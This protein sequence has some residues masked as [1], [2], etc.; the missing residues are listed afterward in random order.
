MNLPILGTGAGA[1]LAPQQSESRTGLQTEDNRQFIKLDG[2]GEQAAACLDGSPYAFY[3]WPGN[4]SEWSIFI[5]G[6]GWCLTEALCESRAATNLGSSLGYDPSGAWG[7]P[8]PGAKTGGPPAY[9]CQGLDPNCTRVF[10]PYCDGS[11]FTSQRASPWPVNG[12]NSSLTFRGLANLDRTLDV[13]EERFGFANAQRLVL[14]GGSAGGLS[15]YIHLDHVADRL[16]AAQVHA[17]AAA[18][19]P[20]PEAEAEAEA[21]PEAAAEAEAEAVPKLELPPLPQGSPRVVGRPV[22]GFFIDELKFNPSQPSYADNIKYGV[23]MFN[24]TPPLPAS[25]VHNPSAVACEKHCGG[26]F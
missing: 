13:L 10:L 22:A 3:I 18:A 8:G 19:E 25:L 1:A 16:K 9:T 17:R 5:N 26:L 2:A 4:S 20:E 7:P 14:Q 6:G 11:C 21:E 12:S 15:T 24:S 23:A